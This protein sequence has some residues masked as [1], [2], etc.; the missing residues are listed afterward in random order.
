MIFEGLKVRNE[1]KKALQQEEG[2][3]N[4]IQ[5]ENGYLSAEPGEH[6][7]K[8]VL[9]GERE[10]KRVLEKLLEEDGEEICLDVTYFLVF[11]AA[12]NPCLLYTS[13]ELHTEQCFCCRQQRRAK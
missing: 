4:C 6:A 12:Q 9:K 1:I 5:E 2:L 8:N 7:G 13:P 10:L 3:P 11:A